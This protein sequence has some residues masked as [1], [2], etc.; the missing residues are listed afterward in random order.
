M[1]DATNDSLTEILVR[2]TDLSASVS[3]LACDTADIKRL[4]EDA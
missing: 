4:L 3:R 1:N 2:L